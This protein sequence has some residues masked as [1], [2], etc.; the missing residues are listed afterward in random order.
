MLKDQSCV[1]KP[2]S[3]YFGIIKLRAIA[4]HKNYSSTLYVLPAQIMASNLNRAQEAN[5]LQKLSSRKGYSRSEE[6]CRCC[7]TLER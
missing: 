7:L 5:L 1:E 2:S 4:D 3:K 6:R